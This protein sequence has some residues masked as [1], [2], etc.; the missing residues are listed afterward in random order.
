M[1]V[2]A[3]VSSVLSMGKCNVM[4]SNDNHCV[5][6]CLCGIKKGLATFGR[7]RKSGYLCSGLLDAAISV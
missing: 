3:E 2:S 5:A 4:L 6:E 1:G 7:K